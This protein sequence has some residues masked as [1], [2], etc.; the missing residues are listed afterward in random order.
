M[1]TLPQRPCTC[2]LAHGLGK[3]V[4]KSSATAL[5]PLTLRENIGL[6]AHSNDETLLKS[7][8]T[9][10]AMDFIKGH[11]QGLEALLAPAHIKTGRMHSDNFKLF[12]EHDSV[13]VKA[14]ER[15][16][17]IPSMSEQEVKEMTDRVTHRWKAPRIPSGG[18]AQRIALARAFASEGEVLVLDEPS[19][20]LDVKGTRRLLETIH[21]NKGKRTLIVIAH[22]WPGVTD[23]A[24]RVV[25]LDK[26]RLAQSGSHQDLLKEDGPYSKVIISSS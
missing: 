2:K 10:G 14:G 25:L 9:T 12:R 7:A 4:L 1:N 20:N 16:T 5:L 11:P 13:R 3:R 24:D 15:V 23:V 19:N 6:G 26:G 22:H 17:L 21:N 18:E 8:E